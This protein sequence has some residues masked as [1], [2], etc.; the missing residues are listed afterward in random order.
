M[1]GRPEGR[2][3]PT[4]NLIPPTPDPALRSS[5]LVVQNDRVVLERRHGALDERPDTLVSGRGDPLLTQLLALELQLEAVIM[6]LRRAPLD[7]AAAL[8]H[9]HANVPLVLHRLGHE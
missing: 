3:L 1:K 4:H 2:P 8:E 7:K 9:L 6:I 5:D